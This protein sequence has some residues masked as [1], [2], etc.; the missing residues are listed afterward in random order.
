MFVN[1]DSVEHQGPFVSLF[2]F[3][4]GFGHEAVMVFFVLS[5]FLVGG[6]VLA[7]ASRTTHVDW[8][9]YSVNRLSRLYTVFIAALLLGWVLDSVGYGYFDGFG[10]YDQ[11]HGTDMAV[12]Q[13]SY[14]DDLS[15][16]TFFANLGMLQTIAAPPFGSNGPL[17]SLANEFWYY[18]MGPA[19]AV[20]IFGA[21]IARRLLHAGVF[22]GVLV[23]LPRDI[24]IYF[25][26][27]LM[28]AIIPQGFSYTLYLVHFPIIAF[29][30]S[31]SNTL[32]GIG[33]QMQPA[34]EGA[35]FY[36]TL[37]ALVYLASYAMARVTE[38][39]TSTIRSRMFQLVD[40]VGG[41]PSAAQ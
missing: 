20:T 41:Q 9:K 21:T 27:W 39:R 16:G 23:W 8:T 7:E 24:S 1:F 35:V 25:S 19:L 28:G 40:K 13:R 32:L 31:C 3:A 15:A 30:L 6:R 12:A 37:L 14:I 17:W 38:A 33:L 36:I 29:C 4:T 26:I 11:S 34:I 18:V 2:Y 22:L 5:G 10:L